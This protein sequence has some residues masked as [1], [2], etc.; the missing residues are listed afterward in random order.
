M[1]K[2]LLAAIEGGG[3]KFVCALGNAE[4]VVASTR[5]ETRDATG[6]L[7][8]VAAFFAQAMAEHGQPQALGLACFGPLDLDPRSPGYGRLGQSCPKPGWEGFD[9]LAAVQAFLPC[10]AVIETDVN[11]AAFAETRVGAA[12]DCDPV[13]YVTVGTGIGI[14]VVSGGKPVHGLGHPEGGHIYTRRHPAHGD[15]PGVCPAHGDCVEGLASGPAFAASW[16]MT[17]DALP[18]DD[19][20]WAVEADYLGQICAN[21]TL[22]MAPQKIVLGGGVMH[23]THLY[24][25]V[26]ERTLHWLGGFIPRLADDPAEIERLVVPPGCKAAPGLVGAFLLAESLIGARQG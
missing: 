1:T 8:D 19:P 23:R 13:A 5:I 18:E 16:G 26:R 11:A 25:M 7:A 14:G 4:T 17:A 21:L 24:P 9:L 3:T 22:I 2:P 6:T 15:F 10:P 12:R 20:A